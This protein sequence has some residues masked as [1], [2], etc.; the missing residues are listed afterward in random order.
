MVR[1]PFAA[2]LVFALLLTLPAMVAAASDD[3][4]VRDHG[5]GTF[6]DRATGLTWVA[7]ADFAV[8]SGFAGAVRLTRAEA[9]ELVA[10]MN[11]GRLEN[12]GRTDWRL[13]SLRELASA[14]ES[15]LD[16]LRL[17]RERA[18]GGAP[19]GWVLARP[20]AG[21]ATVVGAADA[22]IL[23][24]N[25]V[26]IDLSVEVHGDV[27]AN[28]ASAGPTLVPDFEVAIAQNSTVEGNVQGDSVQVGFRAEISGELAF[29]DSSI[30]GKTK[31]G[32]TSTPLPLPVLSL[33]PVFKSAEDRPDVFDVTLLEGEALALAAGNYGHVTLG[34]HATLSLD[35]G[36]YEVKSI[37][38]A[39]HASIVYGA[40]IDVRVLGKVSLG[41]HAFVGSLSGVPARQ[42]VMYVAGVNGA[43]GALGSVPA[44]VEIAPQG[45]VAAN[46]YAPNGTINVDVH[47]HLTGSLVAA[48]VNLG[49]HSRLTLDSFYG[50]RAPNAFPVTATLDG[51]S[52]IVVTLEGEDPEGGSL[53]FAIASGPATGTLSVITP[54]VP[55]PV[56]DRTTDPPTF[57][58]PPTT[59][60][61]V[62]YTPND[63]SQTPDSFVYT[64]T[65]PQGASGSA[66]VSLVAPVAEEPPPPPATVVADDVSDRTRKDATL[67]VTLSGGAPEGV[68][69]SFALVAGSGPANGSLGAVTPGGEVP[70]RTATVPYTPNAGFVGTDAFQFEA[71][72]T[73]DSVLVCDVG[74]I[75]IEVFEPPVEPAPLAIDQSLS[76]FA[77]LPLTFALQGTP[78]GSTSG[79]GGSSVFGSLT[80][81]SAAASV[82]VGAAIAGNVADS[83]GDFVGDNQN[84][85]P[86][87]S[88]V[89]ISASLSDSGGAGSDGVSRINIEWP[90]ADFANQTI[91]SATVTLNTNR[92]SID[93]EDTFF[94]AF[95][96]TGDGVL[97]L[98]D[99]AG[100]IGASSVGTMPVPELVD[101]PIGADG[102]FSFDVTSQV[103]T[104]LD[105][106]LSH[107]WVHGR[108]SPEFPIPTSGTVRGLQVRSTATSNLDAGL[109]PQLN[110]NSD[111][112]LIVE[113]TLLTLPANGTLRDATGALITVVPTFL[114][115]NAVLTYT[116]NVGFAGIDSFTFEAS[117]GISVDVGLVEFAVLIGSCQDDP[118]F[119]DDGR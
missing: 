37:T 39:E 1:K 32:S 116:A 77:E 82:D 55:P 119:C 109:E 69:L 89:F 35:G 68:A 97:T 103:Q 57:I 16:L 21:A 10:A 14:P 4:R 41:H 81:V 106:G 108:L 49:H 107:F 90:I 67:T 34:P 105:T 25:S 50:N 86:G 47:N 117:D 65:D 24:S 102:T 93:S 44:A 115:S 76:G 74:D 19:A 45:N 98:S 111:Q 91:T 12:F 60:A 73:V 46:L 52:S 22:A 33:F 71:C 80:F 38:G 23:A 78:G 13:P 84:A 59:Q 11:A 3:G 104:A 75:S 56:E 72:G 110:L 83:D 118:F 79:G 70:Q 7:D 113:F 61:T 94:T 99:F 85:L 6:T 26:A 95:Q 15:G 28:D 54:I 42:A 112:P 27:V 40:P 18:V 30:G 31:I 66:T 29:N 17:G 48:D 58:Q 92:G 62:V 63:G 36:V 100:G 88:P 96:T 51:A 114:G 5:N 43:D 2:A 87:S 20:V 53:T 8:S 64:V 9:A 101:Q